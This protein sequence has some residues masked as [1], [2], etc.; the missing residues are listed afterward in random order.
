MDFPKKN[1]EVS[2]TMRD[3]EK[4][5]AFNDNLERELQQKNLSPEQVREK[6]DRLKAEV[7]GELNKGIQVVND[8]VSFS[9]SGTYSYHMGKVEEHGRQYRTLERKANDLET[10][11]K[12]H[13]EPE[14]RMAEVKKLRKEA[15]EEKKLEQK[16][17][18]LAHH[19]LHSHTSRDISF[20]GMC[21]QKCISL[22]IVL[23]NMAR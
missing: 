17:K 11:I 7:G 4:V 15:A 23:G 10:A 22:K 13:K 5:K 14:S 16:H 18:G 12:R 19:A 8:G 9:G 6:V 21:G 20:K 1:T 3:K 2:E